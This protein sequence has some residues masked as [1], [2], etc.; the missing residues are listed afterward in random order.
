[1][2]NHPAQ[3]LGALASAFCLTL[4]KNGLPSATLGK[5]ILSTNVYVYRE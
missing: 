4:D 3:V 2:N 1:M 5:V